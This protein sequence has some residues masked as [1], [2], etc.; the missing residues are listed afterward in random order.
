GLP[1][2]LSARAVARRVPG[3]RTDGL[4]GGGSYLDGATHDA[5]L[6]LAVVLSAQAHGAI[7]PSRVEALSI[8]NGRSGSCVRVRDHIG[9]EERTITARAVI[10]SGG[11]F[12]DALRGR[13]GLT[14]G[15]IR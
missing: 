5:R 11:P 15:W 4:R 1:R 12:T 6:T 2:F 14:R 10:L 8:E 7:A 3:I 9:G 13:A